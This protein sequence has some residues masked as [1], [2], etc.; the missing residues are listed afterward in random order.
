MCPVQT[1]CPAHRISICKRVLR[2]PF[3]CRNPSNVFNLMPR[4]RL[5][6][7]SGYGTLE[8]K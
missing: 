3:T 7:C 6:L 4:P 1:V 2:R 5:F 8:A